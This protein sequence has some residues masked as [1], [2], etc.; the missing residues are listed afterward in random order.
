MCA[1]DA[2]PRISTKN[3]KPFV[4]SGIAHTK[5]DF[6]HAF[7]SS[8]EA[9]VPRRE[10]KHTHVLMILILVWMMRDMCSSHHMPHT[11]MCIY[12]LTIE[13]VGRIDRRNRIPRLHHHLRRRHCNNNSRHIEPYLQKHL[14]RYSPRSFGTCCH[15]RS[16]CV[17]CES[18][19]SDRNDTADQ[20]TEK[21]AKRWHRRQTLETERV[22]AVTLRAEAR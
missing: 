15:G 2:H 18:L 11:H 4:Y 8:R 6:D 3:H 10:C 21:S 13:L 12:W 17:P 16:V 7:L 9:Q 20:E 1:A 19:C 22:F 5:Q 14:T